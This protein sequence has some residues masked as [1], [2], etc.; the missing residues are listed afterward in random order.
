MESP[1]LK[2]IGALAAKTGTNYYTVSQAA[3][4]VGRSADTLARWR[5]RRYVNAPSAQ[6]D[7]DTEVVYLYTDDDIRE[8]KEFA[9]TMYPGRRI[10]L[11][12]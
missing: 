1:L 9:A 7:F 11:E 6:C 10:D 3:A 8:L 12:I 2:Y 5:K 4:L